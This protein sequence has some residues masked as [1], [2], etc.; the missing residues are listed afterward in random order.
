MTGPASATPGSDVT[1]VAV[2]TAYDPDERLTQ[3]VDAV[4]PQVAAVVVV[5][6]GSTTGLA[7][8]DALA[9]RPG[10]Q[11]VRQANAGVA[12]ALNAG[13]AAALTRAAHAVLTLDQDTGLPPGYVANARAAWRGA[14]AHGL[15]VGFVCAASYRG[16]PIPTR[17]HRGGFAVAFD[18]L[19]SGCL[20]PAETFRAVGDYDASLVI[21]AVDS[22]FT[23]RCLAAGL[24]PVVGPDCHLDHG[25]GER[26]PVRLLGRDLGYNRHAPQRV[27]YMARN[28]TLLARRYA[29]DE[30]SW[31]ARRLVE[32]A[33]AHTLRLA[34][35]PDRTVLARAALG[36]LLDGLRGR[37]GPRV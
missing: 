14:A 7:V 36:G 9:A 17:G 12:A 2:V 4:R 10:V 29:R 6:D 33:K 35:S 18:P 37:S 11:L 16:R 8:L 32:E 28:G 34:F 31:V 30:P 13:V 26:T 5:D 3:L 25:M 1:V 15:P 20:V 22:E 19:Q 24:L 21:D 23:A 27:Y